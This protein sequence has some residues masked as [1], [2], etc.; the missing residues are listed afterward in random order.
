MF[1]AAAA[2][3]ALPVQSLAAD[4]TAKELR[5]LGLSSDW[6]NGRGV[7][8][9]G[10]DGKVIYLYGQVQ[11]T[12][13]CA[14]LQVCDIELQPGEAVRNVMVG[15]TVRWKVDPATSGPPETRFT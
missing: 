11:P 6:R 14:P 5:A 9:K 3:T 13:V 15:D 8:T 2:I 10:P 4:Y 12:V 7:I 1:A